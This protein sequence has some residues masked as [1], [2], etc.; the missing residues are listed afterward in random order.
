M[1]VAWESNHT[2]VSMDSSLKDAVDKFGLFGHDT[3]ILSLAALLEAGCSL[4]DSQK[5]QMSVA[6][7]YD[8]LNNKFRDADENLLLFSADL[9]FF[10]APSPSGCWRRQV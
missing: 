1:V 8:A 3:S 2:A 6:D 7:V 4:S 9:F 10:H 5:L